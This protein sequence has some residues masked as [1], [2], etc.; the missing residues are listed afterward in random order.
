[1][2]NRPNL[3]IVGAMKCGTTVMSDFLAM[4]PDIS[5]AP[6]KEIHY[7]SLNFD[8]GE[9][10]YLSQFQQNHKVKYTIDASPTYL[11][12]CNSV[13]IPK[14][15]KVFC[16]EAKILILIRDPVERLISHFNHMQTVDK[17]SV[18][19]GK[20]LE[21]FLNRDW[22]IVEPGA[23]DDEDMLTAVLT[24]SSYYRKISFFA[25]IMGPENI[26]MIHNEDLRHDGQAVMD[27]IFDFLALPHI[28]SE[29]FCEQR[30]VGSTER[31]QVSPEQE[32]RLYRLFGYDYIRSCHSGVHHYNATAGK[33]QDNQPVGAIY[34]GVAVGED[35]WLF[36]VDGSN[37]VLDYFLCEAANTY[38]LIDQ[39]VKRV[40]TRT[41]KI[42]A[43]GADFMPDVRSGKTH[44]LSQQAALAHRL[45]AESWLLVRSAVPGGF[46]SARAELVR[47]FPRRT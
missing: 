20:S 43:L 24:F 18:L 14:L 26:M 8:K 44:R 9:E 22:P 39:W 19:K 10:W 4:H 47:R 1:M 38:P 31:S 29:V 11:D 42:G 34:N 15:I 35:G 30:Y 28:E 32:I 36:L 25:D 41:D 13:L 2:I 7:F 23:S 6:A 37:S 40:Q 46:K 5:V 12:T 45:A 16:P 33:R 3:F 21:Q 27:S 17:Y